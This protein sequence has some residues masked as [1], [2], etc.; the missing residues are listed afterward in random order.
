VYGSALFPAKI[1]LLLEPHVG[2]ENLIAGGSESVIGSKEHARRGPGGTDDSSNK[3]IELSKIIEAQIA[4]APRPRGCMMCRDR[5]VEQVI[6]DV[7]KLV[8]SVE[9]DG[10]Q[11]TRLFMHQ[12]L[13]DLEPLRFAG[14]VK[15][16]PALEVPLRKALQSLALDIPVKR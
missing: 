10:R 14:G 9:Q 11:V 6:T 16:D 3:L 4:N 5:G 7:L 2:V 12:E 1:S 8:D 15:L 13:C